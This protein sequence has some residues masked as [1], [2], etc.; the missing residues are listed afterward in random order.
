MSHFVG[1]NGTR[2]P[3]LQSRSQCFRAFS[4][5]DL[6][7]VAGEDNDVLRRNTVLDKRLLPKLSE[8]SLLDL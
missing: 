7:E 5:G 1:V 6:R 8:E 2:V 4:E 3:I